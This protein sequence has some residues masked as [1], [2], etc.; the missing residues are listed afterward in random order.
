MLLVKISY[1]ALKISQDWS[2]LVLQYHLII[3]LPEGY[4][5]MGIY[6]ISWDS[7]MHDGL[8][9]E[10]SKLY[11]PCLSKQYVCVCV[12]HVSVGS[13]YMAHACFML[14]EKKRLYIV[15]GYVEVDVKYHYN[16]HI[17]T[18]RSKDPKDT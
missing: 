7:G 8:S 2:W 15:L 12:C 6:Y 17:E 1:K 4:A 11:M 18:I 16:L 3:F 10:M 14:F 13:S 5:C 9:A